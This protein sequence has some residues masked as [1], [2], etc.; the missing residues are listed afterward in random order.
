[1]ETREK[2]LRSRFSGVFAR[3]EMNGWALER[4]SA[5]LNHSPRS[6]TPG[7]V[8]ELTDCGVT[9]EEAVRLLFAAECGIDAERSALE[10]M[11]EREYFAPA[12]RE[13]EAAV[14]END[15]YYRQILFPQAKRGCWQL[16]TMSYEPFEL[17][18][19][20]DMYREASG[21]EMPQ[22]GYF[23]QR[24]FYPAVL[25]DGREWMTVTPNEIETMREAVA[26]ASGHV[27]ALGLG[28]GYFA[29]CVSEK[30]TVQSVTIIERDPDVIA[31]FEE[32]ILPQFAHREKIRIVH[33]DAF[34]WLREALPAGA[35][36][37]VFADLW[38]DVSDGAEMYLRL[39]RVEES[40]PNVQFSYWIEPSL[41]CFIRALMLDAWAQGDADVQKIWGEAESEEALR[42]M[43][44]DER[45]HAC[46]PQIPLAL[47]RAPERDGKRLENA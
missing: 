31:L 11:M 43:L 18:V 2:G 40:T 16:T 41:L 4:M 19:C 8:A 22:I 20:A 38:H 30:A 6:I 3:A 23:P 7:D 47:V 36:T 17:F 9:R 27:A 1:M 34:E 21:R 42:A 26:A 33:A 13:L 35:A 32:H 28:L 10:R 29:F 5:Y 44:T 39:R 14:Y 24:F 46:A 37:F 25:E 15:A 45:L 12:V